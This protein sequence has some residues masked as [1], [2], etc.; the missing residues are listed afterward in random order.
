[1][2]ACSELLW[3]HSTLVALDEPSLISSN[4]LLSW[5]NNV[6][7]TVVQMPSKAGLTETKTY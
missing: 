4:Q 3:I 5:T 1:M 7:L 2:G 6:V